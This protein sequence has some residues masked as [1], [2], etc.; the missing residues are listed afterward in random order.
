LGGDVYAINQNNVILEN[1]TYWGYLY[2]DYSE[3]DYN[4]YYKANG[5]YV[6]Q[7]WGYLYIGDYALDNTNPFA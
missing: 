1:L 6:Y 2:A 3:Y 4:E 5:T 7:S